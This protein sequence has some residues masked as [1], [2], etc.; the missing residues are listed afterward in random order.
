MRLTVALAAAGALG[1]SGT[2]VAA[3]AAEKVTGGGQIIAEGAKGPGDTIAL[4]AQGD[5]NSDTAA[6]KGQ[7]QY[8]QRSGEAFKVHGIVDCLQVIRDADETTPNMAVVGG[9]YRDDPGERFRVYVTDNG[10][11]ANAAGLDMIVFEPADEEQ[12]AE[13][14]RG[15]CEPDDDSFDN[16]PALGRGNVKIH[17]TNTAASKRRMAASFAAAKRLA[18]FGL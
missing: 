9:T 3:P 5:G 1:V 16:L 15:T 13:D 11:G 7:L 4:T 14:G 18:R 8:N 2:A 12:D 17:K 6:A 10:Q